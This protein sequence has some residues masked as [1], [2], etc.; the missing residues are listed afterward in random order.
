MTFRRKRGFPQVLVVCACAALV[1]LA[2]LA[3]SGCRSAARGVYYD[4]M[5]RIGRPKREI[6]R[7][8]V[9][10]GRESQREAQT[11]FETT[12]ERFAA[13]A[14]YEGSDLEVVYKQMNAEYEESEERAEEVRGRIDAIEQVA[15]DLFAEW[16]AEAEEIGNPEL[17]RK[18]KAKLA[19]TEERYGVLI[20]AMQ[21]AEIRM[22]PVLGAFRD[23]VLYLKHNLNAAAV[24]SLEG[25]VASIERDVAALIAEI[26]ASIREAD[27]F[28][29]TIE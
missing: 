24:A 13:L 18:S 21:N 20:T 15:A 23:Q 6:L 3:G 27:A 25:T 11:Q 10:A 4:A 19:T 29:Q 12:Y 14:G 22:D 5:E 7:R 17:R 2:G 28:L 1:L 26:D 16:K 9:E 8:R